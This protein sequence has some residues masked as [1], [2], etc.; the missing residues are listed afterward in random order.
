MEVWI[1]FIILGINE[2]VF[3][4]IASN[5]AQEFDQVIE[6]N[7]ALL[8]SDL[9]PSLPLRDRPF[10]RSISPFSGAGCLFK[11]SLPSVVRHQAESCSQNVMLGLLDDGL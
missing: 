1:L 7:I 10:W 2:V 3:H 6:Q 11:H 5:F 9:S 4:E 8:C